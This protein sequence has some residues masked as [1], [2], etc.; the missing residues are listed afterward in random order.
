MLHN[1]FRPYKQI[2]K[3]TS[4]SSIITKQ[5]D[6]ILKSNTISPN[7]NSFLPSCDINKVEIKS[8]SWNVSFDLAKFDRSA[9]PDFY[10]GEIFEIG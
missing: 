5:S 10:Q 4:I 7:P 6:E 3:Q 2:L 8:S 9:N 1:I